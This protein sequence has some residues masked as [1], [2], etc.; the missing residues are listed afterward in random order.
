MSRMQLNLNQFELEIEMHN[1]TR[2][3][4]SKNKTKDRPFNHRKIACMKWEQKTIQI[5]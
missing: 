2:E 1:G 3:C 5:H 4:A